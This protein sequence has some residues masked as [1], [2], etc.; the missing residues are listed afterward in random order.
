MNFFAR[1]F[2][3]ALLLGVLFVP[4]AFAQVNA[5]VGGTVT[6]TSGAVIVMAAVSAKNNATGIVTNATTNTSGAYEF[7]S[8]QPGTYTVTAT[9]AGFKTA[10]FNN[11]AL[12]QGQQVRLNF[13]MEVAAAGE[14][15]SV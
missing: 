6:D 2:A 8:L 3:S 9:I 4:G 15:V 13:N 11:V 1:V 10:T 7:S 5:T 14:T 12:G